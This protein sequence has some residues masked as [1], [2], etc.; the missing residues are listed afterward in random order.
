M[1]R[2]LQSLLL[3]GALAVPTVACAAPALPIASTRPQF[4]NIK[5]DE[6]TP[7]GAKLYSQ[8][9]GTTLV[10]GMDFFVLAGVDRQN[11]RQGGVAAL[12][13]EMLLDNPVQD[14]GKTLP[15]Q[16]AIRMRG[17]A[18]ASDV[19]GQSVRFYLEARNGQ[20]AE[21]A[22][23]FADVV[24]KPSFDQITFHKAVT[25]LRARVS[26]LRNNPL[27]AGTLMFRDAFYSTTEA[28]QPPLG[29]L[30]D[31][32]RVSSG[33]AAA[34]YRFAY[35]RSG[36]IATVVGDADDLN[37][38]AAKDLVMQLPAGSS[39]PVRIYGRPTLPPQTSIISFRRV[40]APWVMLGFPAPSPDSSD[41]GAML[42]LNAILRDTFV[43]ESTTSVPF[44]ERPIG[45]EY[46]YHSTPATVVLY[47]DGAAVDQS[48]ALHELGV[49][50]L[51]LGSKALKDD[52][53]SRYKSMAEGEYI[54]GV[55]SVS[56]RASAIATL[57]NSGLG[58]EGVNTVLQKI[59]D[60]K[61]SDVQRVLKRYFDASTASFILPRNEESP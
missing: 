42:V 27:A 31:L 29:T 41:F 15:L 14:D 16:E 46:D 28:G 57:A 10:S 3:L 25:T 17:G 45:L 19:E 60:V 11:K 20:L 47:V 9:D 12:T 36:A 18:V 48:V 49:L 22:K 40:T 39:H 38:A 2:S 54:S 21:I 30:S 13:A 32:D 8:F 7:D 6:T 59:N 24:A 53:V 44:N 61:T 50:R 23:L 56:E 1:H 5:L 43:R 58:P 26:A 35:R 34:F 37:K 55:A 33:D 52:Y 4:T 51:V